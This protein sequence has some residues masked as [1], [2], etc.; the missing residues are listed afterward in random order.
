MPKV[1]IHNGS[2]TTL[3]N[4]HPVV[5]GDVVGHGTYTVSAG[6]TLE[7]LYGVGSGEEIFLSNKHPGGVYSAAVAVIE[8][9]SRFRGEIDLTYKTPPSG[10]PIQATHR[11]IQLSLM[12][13]SHVD[14]NTASLN[15][16]V[17]SYS[18]KNDMLKLWD[19]NRVVDALKLHVHDPYG[20][21][22]QNM[23]GWTAISANTET[24]HGIYFGQFSHPAGLPVHGT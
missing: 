24:A 1:I 16:I 18:Y 15:A 22:V 2:T 10:P 13:Q 23:N 6:A 12:T 21:T 5:D 17:D 4:S 14:L 3:P 19:G 20:I 7:F 9:P 8:Q 11:D